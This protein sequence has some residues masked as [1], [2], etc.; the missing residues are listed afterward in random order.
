MRKPRITLL[1]SGVPQ[2]HDDDET[3]LVVTELRDLG[4]D[5]GIVSWDAPLPDSDLV[6]IRSTW[7]YP[8]R[9]TEY[10]RVLADV[11]TLLYNPVDVVRWNTHKG[12]LTDLAAAGVPAVPTTL[13]VQ[14]SAPPHLKGEL[15]IKPAVGA[16]SRGVRRLHAD[17][18]EAADHLNAL[19]VDG[20]VVIQPYLPEVANGEISLI[21]FSGA[22][23][24]AVRKTFDPHDFRNLSVVPHQPSELELAVAG[25]ALNHMVAPLLYARVDLIHSPDGPLVTELELVEP[26]LYLTSDPTAPHRFAEAIAARLG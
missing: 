13:A 12:Y 17:D 4:L 22:L 24:H 3:R 7:D 20:D 5:A 9:L 25:R 8:A 2:P 18:P 1:T 10:L 21:Y 16:G 6:V 23:S 19:L 15:I 26:Y 11:H 14:G